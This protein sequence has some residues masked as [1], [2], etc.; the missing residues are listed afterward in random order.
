MYVYV[1]TVFQVSKT[2]TMTIL[3]HIETNQYVL[4]SWCLW[5]LLHNFCLE[6]ALTKVNAWGF[7]K[8]LKRNLCISKVVMSL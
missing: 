5:K 3:K 4:L 6:I 7:T 8:L 2:K 1:Q